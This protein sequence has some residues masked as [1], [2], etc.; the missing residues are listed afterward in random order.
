MS[1]ITRAA[2]EGGFCLGAGCKGLEDVVMDE[3]SDL[4]FWLGKKEGE[5]V[6]ISYKLNVGILN[7]LWNVTCGRKLHSQQQEF[8]SVYECIDKMTQF[9][10]RAAIFS[11]MPILTKILP[12]SV[13]NIERGRYY[14]N[15]FHEITEKWI[16]EHRQD[17][18]GN[19]TGDLQD[20]YLERI[21]RGEDTFSSE[22]L[23]AIVR[24][25]F[26]IGAES[27]SVMMRWAFR[28]LSCN[29]RVQ[30]R[31]QDELDQVAGKGEQVKW[32]MR[33]SL[34]YTMATIKEIMRFADIA[35]TG[36]MHKTVCDVQLNGFDL[37]HN[38]LVMSNISACHR[39]PK[40]WDKPDSFYPEHF[41]H[42][43]ALVE[44]KPGFLPYGVG[45]RVCPG[46]AL[47]DMQVILS[48]E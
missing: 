32:E 23:A 26:V 6:A 45:K 11:F 9:M 7:V 38:T 42:Q 19:R 44:N 30:Q 33:S 35:P 41:L 27:E 36:L 29:P 37:P 13:T 31:V 18:R 47:A 1:D 8:Q 4:K 15:R 43:G 24:E 46:A 14:R 25:I 39:D 5:A 40:L 3:V 10:S 28:L 48:Q 21:N 22:N 20:A 12:E 17:Y 2:L 16:R 34:P